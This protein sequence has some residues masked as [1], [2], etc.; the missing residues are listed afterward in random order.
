MFLISLYIIYNYTLLPTL[1]QL[2]FLYLDEKVIDFGEYMS[3]LLYIYT[4]ACAFG[5]GG[6]YVMHYAR[7][8]GRK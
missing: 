8:F 5:G 1:C 6:A 7:D 3:L 2:L 4:C